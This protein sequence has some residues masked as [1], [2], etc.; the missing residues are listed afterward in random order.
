MR[1]LTLQ[2]LQE[3]LAALG[4]A[5]HYIAQPNAV[6]PYLVWMEDG[7]ND[8]FADNVHAISIHAPREGSDAIHQTRKM[9]DK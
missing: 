7:S 1:E 4:S 9:G 6:P 2:P 5:Y 3:A 8:L